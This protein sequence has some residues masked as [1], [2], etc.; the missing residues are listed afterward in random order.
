MLV[1]IV[2]EQS[3]YHP[4][5][6]I[7]VNSA[8]DVSVLDALCDRVVLKM[9]GRPECCSNPIYWLKLYWALSRFSPDILHFHNESLIEVLR[10][11]HVPKVVTVHSTNARMPSIYDKYRA[12]F[13]ISDA[14]KKDLESRYLKLES[15]TV[16]NGIRFA[17]IPTKES[18]S[19]K[20]F[21]IVQVGRVDHKVK[22]QDVLMRAVKRI[23]DM[24]GDGEVI[25]DFIGENAGSMDYLLGLSNEMRVAGSFRFLGKLSR[26]EVHQNLHL[27]DLLV[28]PSRFEGFGLTI[29]EAMAAK[30]PVLVSDIDGPMEIIARGRYGKYFKNQ[31]DSDC[32]DKIVEI[33]HNSRAEKHGSEMDVIYNHALQNYEVCLTAKKYLSEYSKLLPMRS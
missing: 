17:D 1:D 14:V 31:S 33:M 10:Y 9:I 15:T 4:V 8:Y 20:P 21:R 32:A 18:Y 2:N 24:H 7:I 30:V 29:V 19:Q 16:Y 23:V 11:Y 26:R 3:Q 5:M 6:L 22:G 12:I 25:V 28:Q 13:S 27:Y